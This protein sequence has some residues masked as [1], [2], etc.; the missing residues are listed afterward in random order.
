M[1]N[2]PIFS[3]PFKWMD[4]EVNITVIG[5]GGTGSELLSQLYKMHFSLVKLGH[6]GLSINLIDGDT[7]SESNLGRQ[8]YWPQDLAMN[9]ARVLIERFNAFGGTNWSFEERYEDPNKE[10]HKIY[11]SDLVITCVDKAK[12]R[13]DFGQTYAKRRSSDALWGDCGNSNSQGQVV[14]GHLSTS[15][16]KDAIRLPNVYDLFPSLSTMVDSDEDSCSHEMAFQKQDFGVNNR[17]ASI[18]TNLVWQLLRHGSI[19]HHGAFVDL[20]DGVENPL[21]IDEIVWQ[22]FGYNINQQV[23]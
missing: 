22:S 13:S 3:T 14:L 6:K 8:N 12:F 7:V 11:N 2:E 23:S 10:S 20:K 9:K 19:N 5:A 15:P 16:N 17:V 21:G 1:M 18:M 4:N